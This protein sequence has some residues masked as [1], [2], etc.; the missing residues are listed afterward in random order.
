MAVM[1]CAMAKLA[2]LETV[3]AMGALDSAM[4]K[5]GLAKEELEL[6]KVVLERSLKIFSLVLKS[7]SSRRNNYLADLS[8]VA[9]VVSE[10]AK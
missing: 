10:V 4:E 5:S 7:V 2:V 1:V 6:A 3:L 8:M 9:I